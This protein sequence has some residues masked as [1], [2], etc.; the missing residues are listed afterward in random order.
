MMLCM[1][2]L[3]LVRALAL[4]F[5]ASGCL[6]Q[7]QNADCDLESPCDECITQSGCG[8]CDGMCV[9]GSS[10]GANLFTCTRWNYS[11]CNIAPLPPLPDPC[12]TNSCGDCIGAGCIWCARPSTLS[13]VPRSYCTSQSYCPAGGVGFEDSCPERFGC[14]SYTDCSQCNADEECEYCYPMQVGSFTRTVCG[15]DCP[16][17]ADGSSRACGGCTIR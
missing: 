5:M 4:A 12:E 3:G 1:R 2:V 14:G 15:F 10:D 8:F 7:P 16:G 6:I 11:D 9:A 17:C 13:G